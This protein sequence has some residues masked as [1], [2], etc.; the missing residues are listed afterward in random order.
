MEFARIVLEPH[1][2][3]DY[4]VQPTMRP[5]NPVRVMLD[6]EPGTQVTPQVRGSLL[7]LLNL[8]RSP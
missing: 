4:N 2:R 1:T 7:N 8:P 6:P 5:L 3:V